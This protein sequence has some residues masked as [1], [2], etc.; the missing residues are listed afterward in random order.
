MHKNVLNKESF[1]TVNLKGWNPVHLGT[2]KCNGLGKIAYGQ[3]DVNTRRKSTSRTGRN[4][5]II[6]FLSMPKHGRRRVKHKLLF[7]RH[8]TAQFIPALRKMIRM[9]EI[10]CRRLHAYNQ[11]TTSVTTRSIAMLS[12]ETFFSVIL[13]SASRARPWNGSSYPHVLFLHCEICCSGRSNN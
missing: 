5:E 4:I 6:F 9:H 10:I 8:E 3:D 1:L 12:I 13:S 2:S 7:N 11:I